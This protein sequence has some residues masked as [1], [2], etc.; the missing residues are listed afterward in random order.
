M[1][2]M[3]WFQIY[4][5]PARFLNGTGVAARVSGF[6]SFDVEGVVIEVDAELDNVVEES[7]YAQRL[8]IVEDL[9]FFG[10]IDV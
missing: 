2:S 5:A 8:A 7:G 3:L 1:N 6:E 4:D 10:G 9:S